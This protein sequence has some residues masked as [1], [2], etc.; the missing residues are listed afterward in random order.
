MLDT[1]FKFLISLLI[2][3]EVQA[4]IVV[5]LMAVVAWMINKWAWTRNVV[6]LAIG[7]YEYAEKEGLVQ[8]LKG[9]EKFDPFMDKFSTE[10]KDKYGRDP[11]PKDKAKAVETMEK[12]VKK[13]H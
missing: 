6:L 3:P 5:I 10:F 2:I 7:A 12:A 11:T 9:Y 13:T 8:N 4:F 1:V